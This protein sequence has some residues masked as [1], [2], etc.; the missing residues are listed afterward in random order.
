MK[1]LSGQGGGAAA[2]ALTAAAAGDASEADAA[3][4]PQL[5]YSGVFVCGPRPLWLVASRGGVLPH[6][7]DA[8]HGRVDAFCGFHNVN[9]VHGFI[10]AATSGN[11]NVSRLPVQVRGVGRRTAVCVARGP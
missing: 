4:R 11:M 2:D 5:R 8:A 10:T 9:C 7:L 6:P 3:G 1:L